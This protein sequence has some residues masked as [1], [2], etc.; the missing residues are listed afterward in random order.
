[1]DS[2][3]TQQQN[4]YIE[5]TLLNNIPLNG[6]FRAGATESCFQKACNSASISEGGIYHDASALSFS[7]NSIIISDKLNCI[8]LLSRE[9][10][11]DHVKNGTVRAGV[12][13]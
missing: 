2:N 1:M 9:N 13:N 8:P 11:R 10:P 4:L 3:T 12:S 5:K 7:N 6:K